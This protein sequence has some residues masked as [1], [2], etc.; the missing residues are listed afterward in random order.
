M[1]TRVLVLMLLT[2]WG[3]PA[4]S[5]KPTN[6][7]QL[8][9]LISVSRTKHDADLAWLIADL[10]LNVRVSAEKQAE[11]E[12]LL[13]GPV[14]KRALDVVAAESQFMDPPAELKPKTAAPSF[15]EQRQMMARVIGYVSKTNPQL[16]N[17]MAARVTSRFEDTPEVQ[18]EGTTATAYRPL[19]FAEKISE[20][21]TYRDGREEVTTPAAEKKRAAQGLGT[22]G[23]FGPIL[24]IVLVDAAKSTLA[25]DGWEQS[26]AGQ[27]AVFRFAVPR[28][29]SHYEVN[30]CCVSEQGATY[31]ANAHVFRQ[32]VGYSGTMTVD[33][34]T[35]TILRLLVRAALKPTDPV[36]KSDLL[37][38]YAPVDIGGRQYYCPLRSISSVT[39]QSVAHD[40]VYGAPLANQLQPLQNLVNEARFEDYHVFRSE[41]R[42]LSSEEAA[43]A[44]NQAPR[45]GN[46]DV[47]AKE[48]TDAAKPQPEQSVATEPSASGDEA[49]PTE[50]ESAHAPVVAPETP[51]IKE[52]ETTAETALPVTNPSGQTVNAAS[53][54]T[55]RTTS[56]LVDVALMVFDKKGRPVTD[57]KQG[58]VEVYDNGR[59]QTIQFF[60]QGGAADASQSKEVGH[61]SNPDGTKFSNDAPAT[62]AGASKPA[63]L[64]TNTTVL[65]VD[66]ANLSFGDLSHARGETLRFLKTVAPDEEIGLYIL[67]RSGFQV[68][69]EPTA[70]HAQVATALAQ[71]MPDA[72]DLS[73]AQDEE[74]RNRQHIDWVSRMSDLSYVNGNDN[75]S[76]EVASSNGGGAASAATVNPMDARL[77]DMG[78][79]PERD[80]LLVLPEVAVHLAAIKGPKSLV[81]VSSDNALADWGNAN[82]HSEKTAKFLSSLYLRAEE[83]LNEAHV[84]IYPLDASQ[85]EPG[86]I[87]ADIQNRNVNAVGFNSRSQPGPGGGTT[88]GFTPGRDIAEMHQDLHP[89]Q[90]GIRDLASATGGKALRRAGDIAAELTSIVD[91]GRAAYQ[92]S[93]TPD[94]AADDTF[95]ALTV[96]AIGRKGL[97]LRYRAGYFY[98]KEPVTLKERF[99]RAIWKPEDM[100]EIGVTVSPG[101]ESNSATMR[102]TVAATDL[103]LAQQSDRWM[104]KLDVFLVARDDA[105]VHAQVS[106]SMLVLRL[107]P[108]TYQ[109]AMKDGLKF[110]EP[111][112]GLAKSGALRVIVVD[113]NTGRMGTVTMPA[114][115]V[116]TQR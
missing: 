49:R 86:G 85:I 18:R 9:H 113:E 68:I 59:K 88:P 92:L 22:T 79:N 20:S 30:Y 71:W 101:T 34:A 27:V 100:N 97:T 110:E 48:D 76:P 3:G 5:A 106:G 19:H 31:V 8:E 82:L 1:R 115:A 62:A 67:K 7:E 114:S 53:E 66:A 57:L 94:Q 4:W 13:P 15:D 38:E 25:W 17:F 23:V 32:V 70:D 2:G 37:V 33:P 74:E 89:I 78:S 60:S 95:H 29:K 93:F 111:L 77:Q 83:G 69:L 52:I 64:Q 103:A 50:M 56:R 39:A 10:H 42:V 43:R 99:Q 91:D 54:F 96:K 58:E 104:D 87:G 40:W 41:G 81:W 11:L 98:G 102:V 6:L 36:S 63:A 84:S 16:P 46:A 26:A 45:D 80:A 24:S 28:E 75:M 51:E 47:A 72:Q 12:K 105:S 65:M 73:R 61:P 55:L 44:E 112:P 35:G 90:G 116:Q 108:E 14:S 107:K 21:V 109:K